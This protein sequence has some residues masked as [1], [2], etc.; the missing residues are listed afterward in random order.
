MAG[1]RED[2]KEVLPVLTAFV[3]GEQVQSLDYDHRWKDTD[4]IYSILCRPSSYRVK[5][6]EDV[7]DGYWTIEYTARVHGSVN[8]PTAAG[9]WTWEGTNL[10]TPPWP[11]RS[12]ITLVP[13]TQRFHIKQVTVQ[14]E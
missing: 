7:V 1:S 9:V 3:N 12:D 14:E 2:W 8:G 10:D 13:A 5:P 6:V 11:D 4:H